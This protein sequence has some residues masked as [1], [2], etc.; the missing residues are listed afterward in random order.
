LILCKFHIMYPL[1]LISPSPYICLLPLQP[2]QHNAHTH[3]HTHTYTHTH[4]H[5]HTERERGEREGERGRERGREENKHVI[6]ETI[7]CHNGS[8]GISLCPHI[9]TWKIFIAMC[10]WYGTRSLASVTLSI[11]DLHQASSQL[12]Y[13]FLVS[14]R[15]CTLD[16]QDWPF[17]KSQAFS[18]DIDFQVG[19]LRALLLGLDGR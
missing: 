12:S 7:V 6:V 9:F 15:S 3:T 19:Q 10:H 4:T 1:L 16:H 17:H 8:H 18:D 14:W 5:T 13:H 2:S 11:L